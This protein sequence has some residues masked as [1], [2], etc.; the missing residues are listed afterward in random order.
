MEI[1]CD[2]GSY[3][4][5]KQQDG[6]VHCF[7]SNLDIA[8]T[9]TCWPMIQSKYFLLINVSGQEVFL[10]PAACDLVDAEN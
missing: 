9:H 10:T 4:K 2:V 6:C 3:F 1:M 8:E 5:A 7:C